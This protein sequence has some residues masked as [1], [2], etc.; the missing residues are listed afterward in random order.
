ME[1]TTLI[2][3][4][5][6]LLSYFPFNGKLGIFITFYIKEFQQILSY[7]TNLAGA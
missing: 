7:K 1:G 2:F 4:K 6:A 3:L 5:G